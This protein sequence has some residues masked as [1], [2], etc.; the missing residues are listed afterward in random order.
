MILTQD[1]LTKQIAKRE[2]IDVAI[3]RKVFKS[4]DKIIFDLLSSTTPSESNEIKLFNGISIKG[5]YIKKHKVNRGIFTN[6]ICHGK[7]KIKPLVT[8]YYRKK[9]NGGD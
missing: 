2:D 7:I 5:E 8:K 3:V 9:I 6:H 1:N 4:A